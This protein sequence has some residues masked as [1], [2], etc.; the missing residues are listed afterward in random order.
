MLLINRNFTL[1]WGG[2][3]VSQLGDKLY[4]IALLWWLLEKTGSPLT[5]SAFMVLATLPEMLLGPLAGVCV[6]RWNRQVI[7]VAS[8]AARGVIVALLAWLLSARGL[9]VWQVYVAAFGISACS[10]LANPAIQALIPSLVEPQALQ[11]ANAR[12]QMISGVTR[13]V[14]PLAGA[15]C[16]AA[17]GYLPVLLF[18]AASYL[19]CALAEC[20]L[21][22]RPA[23][24][25]CRAPWWQSL[26]EGGR[27]MAGD[28]RV[29][30]VVQIVAL[31][32][33]FFG[34]L[35]VILPFVARRLAGHGIGNLGVLESALGA[36]IVV[37]AMWLARRAVA[38]RF[39]PPVFG[40]AACVLS[41]GLLQMLP[42]TSLTAC[43]FCCA[44]IGLAV[45]FLSVH[46]QTAIQRD[47]PEALRGRVFSVLSSTG[48]VSVPLAMGATGLL[49]RV[50]S[51]ASLL[52]WAALGLS[53]G[54][55][56]LA[57]R[58]AVPAR[59]V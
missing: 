56:L 37:G 5:T 16:V 29:K 14:G 28:V 53:A 44:G 34:A 50:A 36:G 54:G 48:N 38:A 35:I 10:A 45:A 43:A 2:Q 19:L 12:S 20:G 42:L 27:H 22:C 8:D 17:V 25:P 15:A 23:A 30:T 57:Y 31:V 21:R 13:I 26:R 18:N 1:L 7:V 47:V 11:G 9:Q 41:L 39:A 6:D 40:M 59:A 58:R 33:V 51:P 52:V 46:W 32:H 3:L 55:W 4:G 24:A 49:L